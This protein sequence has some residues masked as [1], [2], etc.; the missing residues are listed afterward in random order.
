[1]PATFGVGRRI[2][3]AHEGPRNKSNNKAHEPTSGRSTHYGSGHLIRV[4][5]DIGHIFSSPYP[6]IGACV[7]VALPPSG[8]LWLCA[9]H[10]FIAAARDVVINPVSHCWSLIELPGWRQQPDA[11][12]RR[13][14]QCEDDQDPEDDGCLRRHGSHLSSSAQG[15]RFWRYQL[16]VFGNGITLASPRGSRWPRHPVSCASGWPFVRPS[17]GFPP[18]RRG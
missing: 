13:H 10:L 8:D 4:F 7:L 2:A 5:R 15:W 9:K 16:A 3:P 11:R 18:I 1:V 17:Q 6:F 14:D 12:H